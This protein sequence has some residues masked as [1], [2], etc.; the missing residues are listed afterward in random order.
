ML[1]EIAVML[2]LVA[3][4]VF[5]S[6]QK[7]LGLLPIPENEDSLERQL[8]QKHD[9]SQPHYFP[10][11]FFSRKQSSLSTCPT[12]YSTSSG[13]LSLTP[14]QSCQLSNRM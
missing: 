9:P 1:V 8:D 10:M 5:L 13:C 12:L 11:S 2:L 4:G 3:I 14:E 7:N 6:M